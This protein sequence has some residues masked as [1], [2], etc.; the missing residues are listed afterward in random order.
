MPSRSKPIRPPS[1]QVPPCIKCTPNVEHAFNTVNA[2]ALHGEIAAD[3]IVKAYAITDADSIVLDGQ[4]LARLQ[5]KHEK[6]I[7]VEHLI[8]ADQLDLALLTGRTLHLVPAH[9]AAESTYALVSQLFVRNGFWGIGR[10]VLSDEPQLFALHAVDAR[11]VLHVLAWP[12]QLRSCPRFGQG[13]ATIDLKAVQ[14]LEKSLAA[15]RKPF[16]WDGYVDEFEQRLTNLV[17]E[18]LAARSKAVTPAAARQTVRRERKK[19]AATEVTVP[20]RAG[21]A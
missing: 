20:R 13:T 16:S 8:P 1:R 4:D 14:S 3:E 18:K 7:R 5:P 9:P 19:R 11:L 21:A 15:L 17:Q 10:A 2:G 12:Q 6:S